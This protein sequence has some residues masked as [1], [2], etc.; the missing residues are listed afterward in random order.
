MYVDRPTRWTW[1]GAPPTK[2]KEKAWLIIP[3][4]FTNAQRYGTNGEII[5]THEVG[6]DSERLSTDEFKARLQKTIDF[7]RTNQ[8]P[9]WQT[10]VAEHSTVLQTL[11]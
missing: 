4:D 1:H 11:N 9:N 8:R 7:V 3:V 10:I 6:E 5:P 2:F